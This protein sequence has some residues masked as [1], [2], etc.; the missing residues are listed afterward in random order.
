MFGRGEKKIPQA[1]LPKREERSKPS[2]FLWRRGKRGEDIGLPP[3]FI[4]RK[5]RRKE[6]GEDQTFPLLGASGLE[7]KKRPPSFQE[8]KYDGA[9]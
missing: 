8:E 7:K 4:P 2:P 6:Q 1:P 3:Y 5:E 9:A